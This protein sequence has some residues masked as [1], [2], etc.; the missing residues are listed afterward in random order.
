MTTRS[1][2]LLLLFVLIISCTSDSGKNGQSP[3]EAGMTSC[4]ASCVDLQSDPAHCGAC[5]EACSDGEVCSLGACEPSC[6]DGLLDCDGSC[7]DGQSSAV[8]CGACGS[9]CEAGEICEDGDCRISCEEGTSYCGEAC[10]DTQTDRENCGSCGSAC[11]NGRVCVS[12]A[13]KNDCP[14]PHRLC[15]GTCVDVEESD[16]HCGI[17]GNACEADEACEGGVCSAICPAPTTYCDHEGVVA[18][19]DLQSDASSCGSCGSVCEAPANAHPTCEEGACDFVCN[20]GWGDCDHDPSNG[21]ELRLDTATNCGSCG[22][23]C[24]DG[25]ACIDGACPRRVFVTSSD[26]D[27]ALGGTAGGD[28]ICRSLAS[29]AGLS[30]TWNAYLEDSSGT[31]SSRLE[32]LR[33]R[34]IFRLDGV[35]VA[36]D[37]STFNGSNHLAPI[38]LTEEL[39]TKTGEV[40]VGARTSSCD[41][42]SHNE[43]CDGTRSCG[44]VGLAE[45]VGFSWMNAYSQHCDRFV[46]LY[47]IED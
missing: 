39:E 40:W 20:D 22:N 42:W 8:H 23:V 16:L 30:G 17:C 5:S 2:A 13:C 47:C 7:V 43:P 27:G 29:S 41:D 33:D 9:T 36:E 4:D 18:C 25:N 1:P 28:A 10:V 32:P 24:L 3:C 46:S 31:L 15:D 34:A 11:G 45:A 21:C 26:H 19:L 12:G 44:R 37:W 14:A 35:K 6:A 38:N